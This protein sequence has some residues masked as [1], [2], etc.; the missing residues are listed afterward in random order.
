MHFHLLFDHPLFEE[1][2]VK[3][4]LEPF[5]FL[6]HTNTYGLPLDERDRKSTS[7]NSRHK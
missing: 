7:L 6:V 1:Q 3:D 4:V 2:P 5:G